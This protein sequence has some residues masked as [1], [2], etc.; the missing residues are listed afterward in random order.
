MVRNRLSYSS[1]RRLKVTSQPGESERDFRIRLSQ[2]SR[3]RRDEGVEK[4]RAKYEAKLLME[5]EKLRRAKQ[6]VEKE[7]AQASQSTWQAAGTVLSSLAGA[8]LGRKK[9]S[10]ANVG[11][12]ASAARAASRAAQQRGD[13]T[14]AAETVEAVQERIAELESKL[15]A[16]IDK[17]D[18]ETAPEG[19]AVERVELRPKKADIAVEPVAL[20][21]V[22]EREVGGGR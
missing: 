11:R 19:F 1:R 9:V 7:K 12:A 3:E 2:Q 10:A 14:H 5:G 8:L 15:Q 13:V 16:D 18:S 20:V 4:L 6:R 17:L 21:W 22:A